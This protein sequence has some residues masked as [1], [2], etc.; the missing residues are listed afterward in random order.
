MEN[1]MSI[2]VA[3]MRCGPVAGTYSHDS[4]EVAGPGDVP[5]ATSKASTRPR[6]IVRYNHEENNL[7]VVGSY[8]QL[9]EKSK[10]EILCYLHDDV[11]IHEQGWDERVLKE[12]DDPQVG[13][14]GFGGGLWHGTEELYKRPY[15]LQQLRRGDYRSNVDDAEVHGERFA[16][17]CN[18]AVLDGYA[19]VLRRDV[20]DRIG[21]WVQIG[22]G[23]AGAD[24]YCYDYA[25]C[26]LVRRLGYRIRI[27][28]IR[29]HHRGG[30]TSV[31]GEAKVKGAVAGIVGAEAYERSHRWFY[32][33]FRDVMPV[34]VRP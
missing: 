17:S 14:V 8:Q 7:G 13:L 4:W 32:E 21:G 33:E 28:G 10:S 16:G 5:S 26:G 34:K 1:R 24:F 12:F 30:G 27:V 25:I 19:I 2:C 22:S 31:Q 18:A 9:Y 15:Q 23:G 3:T 29:C 11:V 6:L 20:L